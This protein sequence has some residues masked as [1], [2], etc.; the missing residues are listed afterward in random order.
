[1]RSYYASLS[2]LISDFTQIIVLKLKNYIM[3]L[4]LG[5]VG[6]KNVEMFLPLQKT[7]RS[8]QRLTGP[9]HSLYCT[10]VRPVC[11]VSLVPFPHTVMPAYTA[12]S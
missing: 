8:Q 1:M 7:Y 4:Y 2:L 6:S 9:L 3:N 12:R 10:V 5:D 11:Y